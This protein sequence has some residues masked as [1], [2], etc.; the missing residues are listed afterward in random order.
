MA[1]LEFLFE[2]VLFLGA[3]ELAQIIYAGVLASGRSGFNEIRHRDCGAEDEN[4]SYE[5]IK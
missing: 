4:E 2:G 1:G 3:V 5:E